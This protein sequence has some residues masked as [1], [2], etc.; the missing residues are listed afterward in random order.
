MAYRDIMKTRH[1][2]IGIAVKRVMTR[3]VSRL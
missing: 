3:F 1:L 2:P